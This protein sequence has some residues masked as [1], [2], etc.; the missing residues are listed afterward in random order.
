MMIDIVNT[1]TQ[2]VKLI[3]FPQLLI[4]VITEFGSSEKYPKAEKFPGRYIYL[5]F[6]FWY[7]FSPYIW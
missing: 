7:T 1:I 6:H 4:D 3:H 2:H 5:T